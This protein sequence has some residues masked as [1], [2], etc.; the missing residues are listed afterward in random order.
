MPDSST[1]LTRVK[2]L[3]SSIQVWR[4]HYYVNAKPLVTDEVYDDA[5]REL[6]L[7]IGLNPALGVLATVLKEVGSDLVASAIATPIKHNSR[8]LSLEK[9]YDLETL[10]AW[11]AKHPVNATYVVEPKVDGLSL[12]IRYAN[13]TLWL[14]CTRGDGTG[15]EDVTPAAMQ[16]LDIP[17]V[18]DHDMFPPDLE[19]RGEVF[20]TRQTLA[21]LNEERAAAGQDPFKTCRNAA[22]GTLKLHDLKEVARRGLRFQPWQILGIA[23]GEWLAPVRMETGKWTTTAAGGQRY[24]PEE[25]ENGLGIKTVDHPQGLEHY[26]A[27]QWY[28]QWSRTR[29][30]QASR[31]YRKEDLPGAIEQGWRLVD[32]LWADVIGDIDGLVVKVQESDIRKQLG[33][34][35]TTPNWAIAVKRQSMKAVTTLNSVTWQVGRTGK[36]TPVAELEPVL[37]GG[38][39]NSRGNLVNITYMIGKGVALGDKVTIFRGGEVIPQILG[40]AEESPTRLPIVIPSRCPSCDSILLDETS[41]PSKENPEGVRTLTCT[42]ILC[43]GRLASHLTYIGARACLD[44]EGL[45]DVLAEQFVSFGVVGSLDDLWSWANESQAYIDQAGEEAF[46]SACTDSGF[47]PAQCL[48]LISGCMKAKTAG[49]DLWLMALGIPAIAKELGKA[50]AAYLNLGSEDLLTLPERLLDL[51]PKQVD[52]L[53]GERIKEITAWAMNPSAVQ[54]LQQLHAAG[55]RPASTVVI[56]AGPQPLKGEVVLV[57]GDMGPEREHLKKQLE[58]LGAV[59]KTSISGKLTL[60]LAGDGAGPSKLAQVAKL[61]ESPKQLVKIRVEGKEWLVKV[62]ESAGLVLESQG[63]DDIQDAF[64][65]L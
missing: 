30:C 24:T 27:L 39:T 60:V 46:K 28:A 40:V 21:G 49:W 29:Q 10:T 3:N 25:E 55:V 9:C 31:V 48:T 18:L 1:P 54:M 42:N 37:C 56:Q 45:G 8:M 13:W 19:V 57:T 52:G 12:S 58:S 59:T 33:E 50:L 38:T 20:F 41:A 23:P 26:E 32:G 6:R 14:A 5:E 43:P 4:H 63:M 53:G 16:I 15:G 17:H 61:N 22:S 2:A 11:A 65:G 47:P 44:I 62:F 64:D 34:G 36:I 7:L 35:S 51:A